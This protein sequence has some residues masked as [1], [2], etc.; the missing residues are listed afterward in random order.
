MKKSKIL[1]KC[2]AVLLT[3]AISSPVALQPTYGIDTKSI[4]SSIKL[5][6]SNAKE[7]IKNHLLI[8]GAT[9][10][11]CTVGCANT[12]NMLRNGISIASLTMRNKALVKKYI[13][14][15]NNTFKN[16]NIEKNKYTCVQEGKAWC[17]LACIQA[18]FKE[19]S[20][21]SI[22]SQEELYTKMLGRK[23]AP[24]QT[25]RSEYLMM[26]LM[27]NNIKNAISS[28]SGGNSRINK[29]MVHVGIGGFKEEI[30]KKIKKIEEI[31]I[32]YYNSTGKK[33]FAI[34]DSFNCSAQKDGL[35]MVHF[36][37]IVD[38]D[39]NSNIMT[40][41]DP[42]SGLSRKEKIYDFCKRYFYEGGVLTKSPAIEMMSIID[43]NNQL[44]D[45]CYSIDEN[46]VL[47]SANS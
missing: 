1:N 3:T 33:I 13:E 6:S 7:W 28:M 23:P 47:K 37:N 22:K 38:I 2:I 40:I 20:G 17:W 10:V 18:M 34:H 14:S 46:N 45:D 27:N 11:M 29:C 4:S 24:F 16:N 31:I 15:F 26:G 41:E 32:N 42:Q 39:E 12:L 44:L 43:S 36:V 35:V 19:A 25:I 5:K 9:T 21:G 8:S 30:T